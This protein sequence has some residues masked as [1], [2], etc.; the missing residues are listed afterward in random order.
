MTCHSTLCHTVLCHAG[1]DVSSSSGPGCRELSSPWAAVPAQVPWPP[2]RNPHP[3]SPGM[4]DEGVWHCPDVAIPTQGTP[5]NRGG[6]H[7]TSCTAC[8]W[9]PHS[10]P[11]T[12]AAPL[13]SN[14]VTGSAGT[15]AS[16]RQKVRHCA[17]AADTASVPGQ[18]APFS[19]C[20]SLCNPHCYGAAPCALLAA[21]WPPLG[22]VDGMGRRKGRSQGEAEGSGR[23]RFP[24]AALGHCSA[25]SPLGPSAL[26]R[27]PVP[28]RQQPPRGSLPPAPSPAWRT[29]T[30]WELRSA[31]R[32][33][34]ALPAWSQRRVRT[35]R[36]WLGALAHPEDPVCHRCLPDALA[37]G[38]A[39]SAFPESCRENPKPGRGRKAPG[40]RESWQEPGTP[41]AGR[42][43]SGG[44]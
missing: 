39:H 1:L 6:V 34:A 44:C 32:W 35:R 29:R 40:M 2:Q 21:S 16:P 41:G 3:A 12:P 23:G 7:G 28:A 15:A 11:M 25:A 24:G 33:P 8:A 30:A 31:A 4:E 20:H 19:L 37:P 26:Q 10:V 9:S 5:R 42:A 38:A 14:A 43:A 13:D 27:S 22:Y 18:L 17:T 36:G